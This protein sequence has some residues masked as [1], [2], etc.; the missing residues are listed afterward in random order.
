MLETLRAYGAGLMAVAGLA[1]GLV[2]GT[3]LEWYVL[4]VVLLAETGF[5]FPVR[6]P[7]GHAAA[8]AAMAVVGSLLAG[9]GPALRAARLRIPEAIAYE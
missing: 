4:R 1:L 6:F 5:V 7:W 9:L 8:I 3:A 2:A